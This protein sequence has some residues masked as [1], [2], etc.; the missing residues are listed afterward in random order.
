M[1][2]LSDTLETLIGRWDDPG[3]YPCGAG[4]Y[5]LPSY[6]YIEGVEGELVVAFTQE[7]YT[8]FLRH[9]DV[10]EEQDWIT[11]NV[12]PEMPEHIEEIRWSYERTGFRT[13]TRRVHEIIVTF[14]AEEASGNYE[15]PDYD[16]YD[17]RDE[18]E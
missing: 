16:D 5:P 18:D 8:E 14:E 2:I 3:D 15:E 11:Q 17:D 4:G 13:L 7:E 6:D 10:G 12:D 9:A 1:K